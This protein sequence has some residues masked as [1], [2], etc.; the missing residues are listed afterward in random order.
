MEFGEASNNVT[1]N[2]TSINLKRTKI[3]VDDEFFLSQ[4]CNEQMAV[5]DNDQKPLPILFATVHYDVPSFTFSFGY[6]LAGG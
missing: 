3:Q 5:D 4:G 1:L 2:T 6:T